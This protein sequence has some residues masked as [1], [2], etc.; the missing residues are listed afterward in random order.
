[1]SD[2]YDLVVI[3]AGATGLG[4]A[5]EA[6]KA[7]R[8]V[9][10]VE[11]EE[12]PGGDCTHYGCVPSKALL[13]TARRVQGAR[14]GP[15]YGFQ[16]PVTVDFAAVM[17]RVQAV[18]ADIERDESP[19]LLAREGIDLVPGFAR[20]CSPTQVEVGG[21]VLTAKRFVLASGSRALVPPIEGLGDVPFLDNK[22]VFALRELPPQLLVLGGGP[23]GMELAQAFQ[24][25]G[26]RVTVVEGAP[27]VLGREEPQVAKVLTTVLE[28]EG[29]TFRVGATVE[30]VSGSAGSLELHLSDGTSVTGT[31]LLVAVGRVPGTEGLDLD[32]AGVSLDKGRVVTDA[33]LRAAK[34]VWAAGDCTSTLQ[35]THVGDEQGRLAA[36]NAFARRGAAW[37]DRV[38]PW[39]TFTEPE[40]AHVGLTEAQAFE[41]YGERALVSTSRDSRGDRARTAG[42]TDG[43]TT[44][45]AVP[46]RIGGM[47]TGRL[48]GMTVV[49]PMAGEVIAEGALAM[50][51]GARV[52]R[53]A[54]T[55]HAY[56]TWSLST[57]VAA[58][59]FFGTYGGMGA[60]P[61][62]ARQEP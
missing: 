1:M 47:V 55:I 31:H 58:A 7:G 17:D 44:L 40:V 59:R 45:I 60:R 9:A 48:V 62:R 5:R 61:A 13:E 38:V 53:I 32:K 30:R 18:I 46:G 36:R 2:S 4:A 34:T 8:R 14:T 10:L 52:G 35:F 24:R 15:V 56:P 26:S 29:V 22:S 19:A 33:R 49:S 16:A 23:I 3:G 41:R 6:R 37:D 20:F 43:F 25:L 11:A 21:R 28:R 42:E 39:V 51:S 50:R 12:R 57:R 27:T 54:Q